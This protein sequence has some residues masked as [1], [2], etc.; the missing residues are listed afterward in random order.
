MKQVLII[1]FTIDES[2]GPAKITGSSLGHV[3]AL[4]LQK[5]ARIL[6]FTKPPI[7]HYWQKPFSLL[8]NLVS[9]IQK[10]ALRFLLELNEDTQP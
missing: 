6:I 2:W 5:D 3:F 10:V 4:L 7:P 1:P 8:P 9:Y